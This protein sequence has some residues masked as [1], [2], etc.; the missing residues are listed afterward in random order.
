MRARRRRGRPGHH[1]G[2]AGLRQRPPLSGGVVAPKTPRSR[3]SHLVAPR[4]THRMAGFLILGATSDIAEDL[5]RRLNGRRPLAAAGG[6]GRIAAVGV[7][8]G[9]EGGVRP[10][11]REGRGR[12]VTGRVPESEGA[13]GRTTSRGRR[14]SWGSFMMKGAHLTSDEEWRETIALNLDSAFYACPR[15]R[16][17]DAG[18]AGSVVLMGSV[19]DRIGIHSHEAIAAAKAGVVGLAKAAAATYA[20][21][22]LRFNVVSPGLTRTKLTE[23]VWKNEAAADAS[24]DMHALHRLGEPGRR[25]R[26]RAFPAGPRQ[27]LDHRAGTERRRRDERR[28]HEKPEAGLTRFPA[29]PSP[30]GGALARLTIEEN[31]PPSGDGEPS[32]AITSSSSATSSTAPPPRSTG[33]MN[34]ATPSGWRRSR[35]RRPTLKQHKL[36]IAYFFSC[37][38]HFRDDLRGRRGVW[39][40]TT[41][42]RPPTAPKTAAGPSAKCCGWTWRN[43]GPSG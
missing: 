34:H 13:V 29:S 19:A 36:R 31:A 5:A 43:T 40:S 23:R 17:D 38:R 11:R 26:G 42:S 32:C 28:R 22:G 8:V 16:Q 9:V 10:V 21:R 4:S 15:G 6:A 33:S 25:R 41:T 12:S 39:K 7:G 27:R 20:S 35:R 2:A 1:R 18:G 24:R 37:M 30:L 14:T 3:S